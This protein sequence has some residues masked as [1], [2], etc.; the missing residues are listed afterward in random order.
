MTLDA[1]ENRKSVYLKY[2]HYK[3]GSQYPRKVSG[4]TDQ[5]TYGSNGPDRG[6]GRKP[7]NNALLP[8]KDDPRPEEAD[9]RRHPLDD[10]IAG[11]R[12]ADDPYPG[13]CG[14]TQR[15]QREGTN[16]SRLAS[17]LSLEADDE[18]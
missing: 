17:V 13:K 12:E 7:L 6:G 1:T 8:L 15:N 4:R 3:Q 2:R 10:A 14:G 5:N 18:S 16:S 11:N 9:S